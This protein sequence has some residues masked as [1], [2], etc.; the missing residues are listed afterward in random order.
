MATKYGDELVDFNRY[1]EGNLST[2]LLLA[3]FSILA[4]AT[5][6]HQLL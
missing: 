3:R 2:S 6:A 4:L 1:S 5:I